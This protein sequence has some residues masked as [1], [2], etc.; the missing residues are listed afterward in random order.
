MSETYVARNVNI[1]N[2]RW[3]HFNCFNEKL[4]YFAY[5]LS[6]YYTLKNKN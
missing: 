2:F 6:C 3:N 4:V 5:K 1:W